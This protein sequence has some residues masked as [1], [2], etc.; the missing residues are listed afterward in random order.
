MT[1]LVNSK[2]V[3]EF[4]MVANEFCRT[5]E[6]A[7]ER[8]VYAV[9]ATLQKINPLLY[10]K[11]TLLPEVEVSDPNANERFVNEESWNSYYDYF[12]THLGKKN[13]FQIVEDIFEKDSE[14][15]QTNIAENLLYIYRDIKDFLLLYKK[16]TTVAKE[17]AI[18][19]C[20]KNFIIHW[21]IRLQILNNAIHI[22]VNQNFIRTNNYN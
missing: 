3:Y 13:N 16:G 6:T 10:L 14:L 22:L 21:G 15:V 8:N 7:E 17:N 20:R 5:L 12:L 18:Y 2:N 19:E 9:L 11:G 4:I 1:D